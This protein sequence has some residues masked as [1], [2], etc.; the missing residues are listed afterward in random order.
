M[1][2]EFK[3]IDQTRTL[4]VRYVPVP[5]DLV[6]VHTEDITAR[7]EAEKALR[8][9]EERLR[10]TLAS[11]DDLVFVLD[12]DLRFLSFLQ[13]ERT[14]G[15]YLPPEE[16][17]GK[18]VEEVLPPHVAAQG[19]RAAENA[20]AT[21]VVQQF[22][23]ALVLSGEERWYSAKVSP[24]KGVE[25][26]PGGVTL[27]A[28]EITKQKRAERELAEAHATLEERVRER[29]RELLGLREKAEQLAAMRERERLA[30]DLHDAVTQTLFSV[31]LIADALPVVWDRDPEAGR[32]QLAELGEMTR[33]AL[34][35]MR[36]L[37]F[38]LR[39]QA[40]E[41]L[42]LGD[43]L[44][45]LAGS[46][47]GR[48]GLR[49]EVGVEEEGVIGSERKEAIYRIAQESLNNVAKHASAGRAE[50]RLRQ[51]PGRLE[52]EVQDDGC[53]FD[54]GAVPPGALGLGIMRERAED[55]GASLSIESEPGEGTLVSVVWVD[56]QGGEA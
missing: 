38:E 46:I 18:A 30:R 39:P 56:S 9:S 35:E 51:R 41:E 31:S 42:S 5:P 53:G 2:Y 29:T 49:I 44:R 36:G 23:Y 10:S 17:Q 7:V 54:P 50:L 37:L 47:G 8:L 34:G 14:S 4:S 21:G 27:V 26:E 15:L 1:P 16:F 28:R 19:R 6:M 3:T 32:S 22:D 33:G 13:P 25:D 40:L 55:A 24:R 43:L 52:L 12:E 20:L 48:T 45:R 11:M